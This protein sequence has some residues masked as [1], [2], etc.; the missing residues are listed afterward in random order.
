MLFSTFFSAHRLPQGTF[1]TFIDFLFYVILLIM[2][3]KYASTFQPRPTSFDVARAAGVSRSSVQL[4]FSN[5]G[6]NHIS[7]ATRERILKAAQ[8]LGYRPDRIASTLR[9]GYSNEIAYIAAETPKDWGT[10]AWLAS[11]QERATQLEYSLATYYFYNLPE[12]VRHTVFTSI[13]SRRPVGIIGSANTVTQEDWQIAK[14]MGVQACVLQDLKPVEFAP[15]QLVPLGQAVY[16]A[17]MHLIDRGHNNIAH[18]VPRVPNYIDKMANK[19]ILDNLQVV[20]DP[21]GGTI[22]ELP[23]NLEQK[24]ACIAV[25]FL[26]SSPNHPTAIL[27]NDDE[28]CFF[29]IKALSARGIRIPE[30]I[31]LVGISDSPFCKFSNPS[32]TSI[33]FD[34]QAAGMNSVNIINAIVQG[35]NPNP[36]WFSFPPPQLLIREST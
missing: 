21:S 14:K 16:L 4:V 1:V 18:V 28:Y 7:P 33:G 3:K 20:F 29:L 8:D 36:E 15:T 2:N 22:T 9:K 31:A 12:T 32:L 11:M 6:G 17:G 10:I 24:D 5:S 27:G 25:D 34:N 30:E 19:I 35:L 13:V 26:L 23:M